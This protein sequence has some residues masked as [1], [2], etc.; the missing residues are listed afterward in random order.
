MDTTYM[1]Y[2]QGVSRGRYVI[3]KNA[4]GFYF[5]GQ[6]QDLSQSL[7]LKVSIRGQGKMAG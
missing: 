4:F 6:T 3:P 1:L 5:S 7:P 2:C